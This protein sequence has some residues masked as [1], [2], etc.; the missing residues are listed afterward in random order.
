M[1]RMAGEFDPVTGVMIHNQ[2]Q[3]AIAALFAETVPEGCPTDPGEKQDHLRALALAALIDPE[4]A[5]AGASGRG[6]A[7][8]GVTVVID[9]RDLDDTGHPHVDWGLDVDIPF[10]VAAEYARRAKVTTVLMDD[11]VL[12]SAPGVMNLGRST[13]VASAAQ[14]RVLRVWYPTC[15]V[16]GCPVRYGYTKAHHVIWWR[17]G[18][19]TDL[20]NLLPLCERHHHRVHD[21]GWE[22]TLGLDRTLTITY[23]DGS[24]QT[25]GPP[26]RL[27]G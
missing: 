22:L 15:A 9:A 25:T 18:G 21:D 16:P 8:G 27:A 24:I 1:W 12:V 14:R 17:H 13:R 23:P 19:P 20:A 26:T 3:A 6:R 2:L 11:E 7:A 4:Y 10:G 5:A